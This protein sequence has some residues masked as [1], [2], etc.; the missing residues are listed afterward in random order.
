ML[1]VLR[2]YFLE[3]RNIQKI[4][5]H[6]RSHEGR[7]QYGAKELRDDCVKYDDRTSVKERL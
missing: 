2:P 1:V 4:M 3:K 6:L 5:W 7:W